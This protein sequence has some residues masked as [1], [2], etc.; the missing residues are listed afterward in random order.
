MSMPTS[1]MASTASGL[2]GAGSI[3]ALTAVNLSPAS[4]RKN[5]SAI[6]LRSGRPGQRNRTLG[7]AFMCCLLGQQRL[8]VFD[9]AGWEEKIL[10][11]CCERLKRESVISTDKKT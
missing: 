9:D 10:A 7:F 2:T 11:R 6:S 3:A 8:G 5:P 4:W 1:F